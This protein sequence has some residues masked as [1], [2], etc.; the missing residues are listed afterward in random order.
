MSSSNR[1]SSSQL[2]KYLRQDAIHE[3]IEAEYLGAHNQE[4]D[5]EAFYEN[6]E[7]EYL[8]NNKH[9]LS[10]DE[11]VVIGVHTLL[12]GM[13]LKDTGR[14]PTLNQLLTPEAFKETNSDTYDLY[15]GQ[16][17]TKAEERDFRTRLTYLKAILGQAIDEQR[18][19]ATAQY[20]LGDMEK[21]EDDDEEE[22][23]NDESDGSEEEEQSGDDEE[24]DNSD[25]SSSEEE[26]EEPEPV[27]SPVP[28]KLKHNPQPPV[29]KQTKHVEQPPVSKQSKHVEQPPVTKHVE[30]QPLKKSS[31][32]VS[33]V[34]PPSPE[35]KKQMQVQ[36]KTQKVQKPQ[37]HSSLLK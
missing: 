5:R 17:R 11:C 14:T 29:S 7:S 10:H 2:K 4:T 1:S 19:M 16:M 33:I 36:Q 3:N 9:K 24:N 15:L 18:A 20:L 30:Q 21:V 25:A 12:D 28:K 8:V 23:S 31:G 35:K 32:K 26:V 34:A 13:N 27:Q 37:K 6:V 22:E